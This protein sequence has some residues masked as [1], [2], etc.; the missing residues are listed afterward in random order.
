MIS[1]YLISG[2]LIT[3]LEGSGRI[4]LLRFYGRRARRL[5]PAAF[6]VTITVVVSG[7]FILSPLEQLPVAKAGA[8]SSLY[9]S[10]F[11]FL[12]QTFDYFAPESALNP[13]LHTWSLSV[14]EQF[15]IIWPTL[16]MVAGNPR[17]RPRSL[18]IA[19]VVLTLFSFVLCLWLTQTKQPWAFY[20][21]PT[22][23]W[24]FGL[25][26]LATLAPVTQWVRNSKLAPAMAGW[27]RWYC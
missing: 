18:V 20:S 3:E 11:W 10:N 27:G 2:L 24:E 23:A 1:G 5:L 21:S 13:F 4:D 6:V 25:G 12:R 22:R 14:E 8:A 15:Y 19:I 7:T 9:V 16:L 26:G 17:S